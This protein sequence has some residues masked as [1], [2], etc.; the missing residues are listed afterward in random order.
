MTNHP[1][2]PWFLVHGVPAWVLA[3]LAYRLH[4][5]TMLL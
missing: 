4:L 2:D 3:E 1:E 5:V